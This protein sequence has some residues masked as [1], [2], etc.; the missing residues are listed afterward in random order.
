MATDSGEGDG[1]PSIKPASP[2]VPFRRNNP[3]RIKPK[4]RLNPIPKL[5][6]EL[7]AR[8]LQDLV[9]DYRS[10]GV[11]AIAEA[12]VK[13][14]VSYL[15]LIVAL[16]PRAEYDAARQLD[17]LSDDDVKRLLAIARALRERY[18]APEEADSDAGNGSGGTEEEEQTPL[19]PALPENSVSF[20]RPA[21]TSVS[22][23]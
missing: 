21:N 1:Q 17:K 10:Y 19:L 5:R 8:F 4:T 15:K 13:D 2:G 7:T 16:M 9:E 6:R 3:Y 14:P 11:A 22:G 23:Y 12:R 18:G 20:T